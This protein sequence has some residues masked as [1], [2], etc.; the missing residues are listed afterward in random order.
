MWAYLFTLIVGAAGAAYGTWQ[1]QEW[2]WTAADKQ[3]VEQGAKDLH[4]ALERAQ[5]SSGVFETKRTS[6]EIQYRTITVTVKEF[7]DRPVYLQQ[8]M[9]SDGLRLLNEQISG[10]PNP[11]KLGL[12]LPRS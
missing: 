10:N 3:R 12:K 7:V 11:G 2:R 5:A 6:N 8:C 4:R 9:D 1:V